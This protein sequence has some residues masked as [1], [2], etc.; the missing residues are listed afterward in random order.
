MSVFAKMA[1]P[2]VK[3][4]GAF[5]LFPDISEFKMD[6]LSFCR[7]AAYEYKVALVPGIY[8]GQAGDKNIRISFACKE[9]ELVEG[10]KRLSAMV[11][12]LRRK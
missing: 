11:E 8:F 6:S 4:E 1:L 12:D 3:P 2:C 5:Y 10:L 9:E 7:K